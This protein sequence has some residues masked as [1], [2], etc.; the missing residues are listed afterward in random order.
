MKVGS[1]A[2]LDGRFFAAGAVR[3]VGADITGLLSF[4]GAQLTGRDGFGNARAHADVD[5]DR[6]YDD[7]EP[8]DIDYENMLYDHDDGI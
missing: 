6:T 1:G 5:R 4:R 2:Y 3:L 7:F 8:D